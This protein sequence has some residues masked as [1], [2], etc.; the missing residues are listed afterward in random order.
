MKLLKTKLWLLAII[1]LVFFWV[2]LF[3]SCFYKINNNLASSSI[4]KIT[5]NSEIL[6][7]NYLIAHSMG[8][9]DGYPLTC[10]LEAFKHNYE[11]G[12]RLFE[13][14]LRLTS[15]QQVVCSHNGEL[16][17]KFNLDSRVEEITHN[18]FMNLRYYDRYLPLDLTDILKLANDYPDL[19]LIIDI[20]YDLL[21]N[22]GQYQAV[23]EK[24]TSHEL[25]NEEV[26]KRIIPQVYN[27]MN[28]K[29]VRQYNFPELIYRTFSFADQVFQL[30]KE[31]NIHLVSIYFKDLT[32][33]ILAKFNKNNILVLVHTVND[34]KLIRYYRR[35]GVYGFFTDFYF[36]PKE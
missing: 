18:Q 29:T 2:I 20:K 14:D 9:I 32:P 26:K 23:M 19:A 30:I 15:D 17:D 13:V 35:L 21:E 33:K 3:F 36:P 12:L 8:G 1:F 28:I 22:S 27:Q 5:L 11:L 25:F 16:K 31:N 7:N 34:E 4:P 6:N 10:S 24:V